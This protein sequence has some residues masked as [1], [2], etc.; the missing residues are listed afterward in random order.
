MVTSFE[1]E[2][3]ERIEDHRQNDVHDQPQ[4]PNENDVVTAVDGSTVQELGVSQAL[5]I[6]ELSSD[7]ANGNIWIRDDI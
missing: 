5:T 4:P 7:P 6:P 3:E 2:A 1:H